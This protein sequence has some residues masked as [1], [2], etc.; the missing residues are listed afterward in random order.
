M[1]LVVFLVLVAAWGQKD[2]ERVR[3]LV[4][5][6]THVEP[7]D[8]LLQ[9]IDNLQTR[10]FDYILLSGDLNNLK[11]PDQSYNQTAVSMCEQNIR[12]TF[13]LLGQAFGFDKT[14]FWVPGNVSHLS[15]SLSL[16][17]SLDRRL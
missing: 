3:F 5:S 7:F 9:F 16:S 1:L 14:I 15:L 11:T 12:T 10:D 6:D 2:G 13:T 4:I 8:P 17:L